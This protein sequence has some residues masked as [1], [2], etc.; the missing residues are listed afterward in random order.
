MKRLNM[1]FI[2]VILVLGLGFFN[3][4]CGD[5]VWYGQCG[6]YPGSSDHALNCPYKGKAKPLQDSDVIAKYKSLCPDLYAEFG[7]NTCCSDAQVN[8]IASQV[9]LPNMLFQRCPSCFHNFMNIWCYLTCGANQSEFLYVNKTI[10]VTVNGTAAVGIQSVDYIVSN[11]SANEMFNS[12]RNVQSP[13]TNQPALAMLCGG[14][15]YDKCTPEN[16]LD[17]M[18]GTANGQTPFDIWFHISSSAVVI[19]GTS[20]T[21]L[22]FKSFPCNVA[23]SN[24]TEACSCQDCLATCTPVPPPVPKPG[25]CEIIHLDCYDFAFGLAFIVFFLLFGCYCMCYNIIVQDSLRLEKAGEENDLGCFGRQGLAADRN[26]RKQQYLTNITESDLGCFERAGAKMEIFLEKQ[27]FNWGYFCARHPFIVTVIA[28]LVTG[29]L[30]AGAALLTVTTDP[31]KLWSAPDSRARLEKDYYDSHF[32]PF[33]R[34]EQLLIS[35]P[36]NHTVINYK[37][38]NYSSLF[39]KTFL[40]ELLDLQNAITK[41]QA[42]YN[43]K[44]IMLQ[45]ICFAP[46]QPEN[47]NCTI[48]SILNYYQNSHEMIDKVAKDAYG[49]WVLADYLDHFQSCVLS[50]FAL[51][52]TSL[53]HTPCMGTFG[54]P[55]YPWVALGGY[56]DKDYSTANAFVITFV[57]NNHLDPKQLEPAKAWEAKYI[58]FMKN[59]TAEH[60]GVQIAFSAERSIED[61]IDRQSQSDIITILCSYL[62]M[63]AYITICLG[64]YTSFSRILVDAKISLGLAGV[65]IVLL[66]VGASLGFYSYLGIPSTL[67]IIEVVPFLVLAVGVDNIFILVQKYQREVLQ[68][69]ETVEHMIGRVVGKVGPSMLLTSL[70]ESLAF[71]L[72]A[73]TQMP[74]V[75]VFSLYAAM[76]VLIDF[77]LQISIFVS[78]LTLDA[79]RQEANRVDVTCCV[80]PSLGKRQPQKGLLYKF[81]SD[82][83]SHFLMKEWVRP[84]V[85]VLFVGWFCACGALTSRLSIGLDQSLAMPKDSYVLNYFHNLSKYLSV[86]PPVYFVVENGHD[87][88]T[89][90]G[91]NEICGVSGCPQNSLVQQINTA[92]R[93]SSATYIA[94]AVSSWLDDYF[95]WLVSPPC[96]R[97]NNKTGDFC[98]STEVNVDCLECPLNHTQRGR[99]VDDTFY[100]YL[101]WFLK[102]NPGLTCGKGG[103]AAYGSGVQL[104]KSSHNETHVGASYFMTYHSV[105]KTSEDY[106]AALKNA[107]EISDNITRSLNETGQHYNVFPYSV[108]YV[109]Y[110]QYLDIVMNAVLNITYCLAAILIITFLLLGFDIYSAII[111]VLT[112]LMILVSIMGL[113]YLWDIELNALSLVN[114]IMAIGIS[115]EFCS[116]I[117]R[118]FTISIKP[119]RK[120]RAK[121]AL[122]YMGSSV[123]S[124]IT[125]TKIAGIIMLAF[126][127]SQL[128]QVFYFR[129]YLAIVL[130]GACHGLIFLPVFLSY[131]GPPVNK[132]KV[133]N[134]KLT[135]TVEDTTTNSEQHKPN[136]NTPHVYE[137]PPAYDTV[138]SE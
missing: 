58:E 82:H 81:I 5:C 37:N 55:V 22:E 40:H 33:Y 27:F 4:C 119:T 41:I 68:D 110:E 78:L 32:T 63:F 124:G 29:A 79:K 122:S 105:L 83:Y 135:D 56:Q 72:G 9:A 6:Y 61:E 98:P 31:V 130:F 12:C 30:V 21:P 39:D 117:I 116:H 2:A 25:R 3:Y 88:S 70:S 111:V 104:Y 57:V 8:T 45:D 134:N 91:Q 66:S 85:M 17:Y 80:Q 92:S 102:D 69:G 28:V 24:E 121:D 106:I 46:L 97:Y 26:V 123:L 125:F 48:M 54:G 101:P 118:A 65:I 20:Y 64:Q 67:I 14:Y 84:T 43:N 133:F 95:S 112:I 15:G 42:E 19:N 16:W 99:P 53:L 87:Y 18:G 131:I 50:P 23:T 136:G 76:A 38:H 138:G 34:T 10:P 132:A 7:K 71:F 126:S 60:P 75:K 109:F 113:M 59:Y 62:I 108:F 1:Q 89:Y 77:L 94:E 44:T 137:N 96:C 127:K 73:L 49:F 100:T 93:S 13:S 128:F 120:E 36:D 74:A 90:A 86:G 103:H 11:K 114:L 51:N 47:N 115:V 52:D 107:R 129:M 35:Q